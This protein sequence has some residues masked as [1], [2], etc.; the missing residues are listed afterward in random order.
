MGGA[1]MAVSAGRYEL[2]KVLGSGA[3]GDVYEAHDRHNGSRVALKKFRG[4][5]SASIVRLKTE[6][7]ALRD[8]YHPGLVRLY[9]LIVEG[10]EA[11]FTMERIDGIDVATWARGRSV[12]EIDR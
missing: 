12:D 6:F 5:A 1:P 7:R 3:T 11:F 9:D 4:D 10:N 2:L 8:I